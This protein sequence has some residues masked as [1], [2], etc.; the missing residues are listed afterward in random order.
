MIDPGFVAEGHG[1]AGKGGAGPGTM[2]G[3]VKEYGLGLETNLC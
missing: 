1:L 2:P 3:P